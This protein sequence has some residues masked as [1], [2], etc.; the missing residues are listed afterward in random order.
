MGSHGGLLDTNSL[1]M[2]RRLALP[3]LCESSELLLALLRLGIPP[4]RDVWPQG[5]YDGLR[6]DEVAEPFFIR[7]HNV[8]R[9]IRRAALAQGSFVCLLIGIPIH[10]LQPIAGRE[11]PCFRRVL[12]PLQEA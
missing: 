2:I 10:A 9:G 12:L 1:W 8:P 5:R 3:H 11:F 7:R 4:H 6:D